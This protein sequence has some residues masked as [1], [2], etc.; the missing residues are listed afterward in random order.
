MSARAGRFLYNEIFPEI[1]TDLLICAIV[2]KLNNVVNQLKIC[3]KG[4]FDHNFKP[5]LIKYVHAAEL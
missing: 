4:N 1:Q 5:L 3:K 2:Y